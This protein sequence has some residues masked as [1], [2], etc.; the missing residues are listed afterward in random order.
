MQVIPAVDIMDARTV[1]LVKGIEFE[2]K[3]Y[4]DPLEAALLWAKQGAKMIHVIDLDAALDK[5]SNRGLYRGSSRR[6]V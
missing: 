4:G 5:R 3:D 1:R 6:R 2:R